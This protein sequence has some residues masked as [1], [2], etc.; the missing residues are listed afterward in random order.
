MYTSDWHIHSQASYDASLTIPELFSS[1]ERQGITDFGLTDHVNR[2]SWITYLQKSR[3][4]VEANPRRGFHLGVELT[5]ISKHLHD[6]DRAHG[7]ADGYIH[8]GGTEPD[9]IELPLTGEELRACGVEYAIG[10]AHWALNVPMERDAVIRDFHRQNLYCAADPRVDILGHPWWMPME[11]TL[12]NGAK[13]RF[14]DM[15][16]I[17]RS[18]HEELA[19][20]LIENDKPME[21]NVISFLICEDF[22]EKLCRQYA[23]YARWMFERGVKL[24]IGTDEHGGN[25]GYQDYREKAAALLRPLGFQPADFSHPKF[26]GSGA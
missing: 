19:A 7:S 13:G 17:P 21:L 1:T 26:R 18:M 9:P 20:A 8:P 12:P 22:P 14:D 15:A 4:L 3:E 5:T 24:T 16:V 25:G 11:W 23:E 2:P 6:Y 10:A